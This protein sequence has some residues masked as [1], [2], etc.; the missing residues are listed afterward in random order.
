MLLLP[1]ALF[2]DGGQ[3]SSKVYFEYN[4][5]SEKGASDKNGFEI[6]RAYLSYANKIGDDLKFNLTADVGRF[7]TDTLTNNKNQNLYLYLKSAMVSW[8]T[9]L[10][11]ITAG[12][13]SMNMFYVQ[14]KTWGYRFLEKSA[15]DKNKFSSSADLGI[16]YANQFTKNFYMSYLVTNGGGYKKP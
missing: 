16:G 1:I 5:Q 8:K 2:A 3:I 6:K 10:G 14:E 11:E 4:F 13:Q 15:M 7:K 9:A 12:V